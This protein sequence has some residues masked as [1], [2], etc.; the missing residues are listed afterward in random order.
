MCYPSETHHTADCG[1]ICNGFQ[2]STCLDPGFITVIGLVWVAEFLQMEPGNL[3]RKTLE[4]T[5][6]TDSQ[7]P[8]TDVEKSLSKLKSEKSLPLNSPIAD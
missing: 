3:P 6:H 2:T 5:K 8:T 4:V 7:L 1:E